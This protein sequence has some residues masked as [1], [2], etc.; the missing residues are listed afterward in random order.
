MNAG[1]VWLLRN[2]PRAF[3]RSLLRKSTGAKRWLMVLGAA[4]LMFVLVAGQIPQWRRRLADPEGA[5]RDL[6]MVR[7][8]APLVLTGFLLLIEV[9]GRGLYFRP[10]EI[11]FL[12]PAPVSRRDL[13]LFQV[14]TRAGLSALSG[15]W[16]AIFTVKWAGTIAGGVVA[17]M[18]TI[19][20][21]QLTSQ[22]SSLALAA[23]GARAGPRVRFAV[24]TCVLG[25][26][27]AGGWLAVRDVPHDAPLRDTIAAF[28]SSPAVVV[29]TAPAIPFARLFTAPDVGE[30][31][32]WFLA[33][34]AETA[35]L[36]SI[37]L[38]LDVAFEEAAIA[39]SR[40]MQE[41][42]ARMRSGEGAFVPS[43]DRARRRRVP[44]LPRLGGVGPVA[45]R[46]LL[47]LVRNPS[48]V[49]WTAGSLVACSGVILAVGRHEDG[50]PSSG[51]AI[52][53]ASAAVALTT[54]AN[55]G[56]TFDFRRD[57][58]RLA[59]FKRLPLRP[60]AL[61]AGQIVT[62][63]IVFTLL[64]TLALA[65][66][67]AFTP[68]PSWVPALAAVVLPPWNWVSAALDNAIFLVLPYRIAPE[69][70]ARVPFVGR[71]FLTMMIKG[72]AVLAVAVAVAIPC[73][74]GASLGET[75]AFV[76]CAIGWVVLV[77]AAAASTWLPAW[78]FDR[79]KP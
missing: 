26:A 61:A 32:L 44:M 60:V 14:I 5:A 24:W 71:M 75:G 28:A 15:L 21:L 67:A 37:I 6:E 33:C 45:R 34:A 63:T 39:S 12:F 29:V 38:R 2:S 19:V 74:V 11:D 77:A 17:S 50:G 22:A 30:A 7:A 73:V 40:R 25:A 79:W 20:F 53:A 78:A 56:F 51:A 27:A 65:L 49:L 18:L 47:E 23:F 76:G 31:A 46:Q 3:V 52:G 70:S 43:A 62:P 57:L 4:F 10:P 59:E 48:S 54:F 9:S 66:V 41:R 16:T 55:Q 36:L 68:L 69:D 58:D 72:A 64:Q 8:V 1:L 42:L 35:V 13:L